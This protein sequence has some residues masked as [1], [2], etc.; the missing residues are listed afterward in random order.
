MNLLKEKHAAEI[1]S[2]KL[3]MQQREL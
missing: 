1:E 2:L 3:L